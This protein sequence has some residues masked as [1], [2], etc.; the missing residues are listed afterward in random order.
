MHIWVVTKVLLC[1][2]AFNG[3]GGNERRHAGYCAIDAIIGKGAARH[4]WLHRRDDEF[5]I[6]F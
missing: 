1:G 3:I 4:C 5:E 2:E 6:L